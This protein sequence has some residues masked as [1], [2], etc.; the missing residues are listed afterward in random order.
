MPTPALTDEQLLDAIHRVEAKMREGCRPPNTNFPGRSAQEAA[1]EQAVIDGIAKSARAFTHRIQVA[2]TRGFEIDQSQYRPP[3][4]VMP[5]SRSAAMA[6][7]PA[8]PEANRPCSK[9]KRVLTIGDL[10][11]DPRFP[12]RME[13]LKWIARYG[14]AEKFEYVVQIGDWGSFDSCTK[15]EPW[16]TAGGQLRPTVTQDLDN[17]AESLRTWNNARHE[18]DPEWKPKQFVTLGNHE[19]RVWRHENAD[20]SLGSHLSTQLLQHF[21]QFGWRTV[22]YNE[23]R[24]IEGVGFTH[25]LTNGAGRAF[26][27][28]TSTQ[29]AAN[30]T[31]SSMITGHTHNLKFH[32]AAKIGPKD[33]VE[34]LEIGCA[35]P[36]G[37][38]EQYAKHSPTN[39]WHG[40]VSVWVNEGRILSHSAINMLELEQRYGDGA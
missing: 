40:V 13:V 20:P 37:T 34:L 32:S 33:G 27:G 19:N 8:E 39:W 17:L 26:G 28:K 18:A 6:A 9:G 23:V 14:A 12:E 2:R 35:L 25:H 11:Q 24:F 36:F 29:R 22:P 16:D 21:A 5:L 38:V 30:E 7:P 4:Y 3:R 1:A 31:V 10:H 15:H